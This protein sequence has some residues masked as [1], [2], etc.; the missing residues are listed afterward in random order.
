MNIKAILATATLIG[1]A[2]NAYGAAPA[3]VDCNNGQSIQSAINHARSGS[4]IKFSGDCHENILIKKKISLVGVGGA[5]LHGGTGTAV[6]IQGVSN[7]TLANLHIEH[8]SIGLLLRNGADIL[9]KKV[10][11]DHAQV[12]GL[13]VIAGSSLQVEDSHVMDNGVSGIELDGNSTLRVTGPLHVA[14]H[15]RAFGVN[16]VNNSSITI[17]NTRVDSHANAMGM[18][19]SVNSSLFLNGAD[20]LLDTSDNAFTGLTA[21]S[22][23]GLFAFG[24]RIESNG[25]KAFHGIS[26]RSKS[27]MDMDRNIVVNANRNGLDG[28]LLEDSTLNIFTLPFVAETP[29]LVAND[30]GEH[31]LF[32]KNHALVDVSDRAQVEVRNNQ[33]IGVLADNGSIMNLVDASVQGNG[34]VDL[35]YTFDSQGELNRNTFDTLGCDSSSRLR[36][37]QAVSCPQ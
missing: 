33:K 8:G 11:I 34:E 5:T 9:L 31:G 1:I 25:N 12:T 24:G 22:G 10:L 18:Q 36:G 30:N 28:V 3:V 20:A 13:N 19:V 26:L 6:T 4:V 27:T 16:I 2:T 21:T 23:S 17:D 15:A 37:T 35:Q 32:A 14:G 7:V 29:R